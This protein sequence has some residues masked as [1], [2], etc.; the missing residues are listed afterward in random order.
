MPLIETY[1]L[2][3]KIEFPSRVSDKIN[4][5]YCLDPKHLLKYEIPYLISSKYG[6]TYSKA[7]KK[8]YNNVY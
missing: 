5:I 7:L 4:Q 2:Q 1:H 8:Q 3:G 6:N